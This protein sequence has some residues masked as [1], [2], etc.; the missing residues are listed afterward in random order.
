MGEFHKRNVKQKKPDTTE[1]MLCD[2]IGTEIQN[3]QG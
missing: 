3:T 1:D 2:F